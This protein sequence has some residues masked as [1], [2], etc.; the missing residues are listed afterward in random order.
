MNTFLRKHF[1]VATWEVVGVLVF[2]VFFSFL[3]RLT[4]WLNWSQKDRN[5]LDLLDLWVWWDSGGLQYFVMLLA[6]ALIWWVI[7]RLCR[8]WSL[9]Y[10]L[11]LH[12]LGLP[13]FILAARNGYYAVSDYFGMDHLEGNGTIWDVYIPSLFYG[14]QFGLFHAYNHFRE[15]QRKLILEGELRQAALRSELSAIKAQL[16]PHFLYNVFNTINASLPS[17]QENT[18][19]LIAKLSDLFR[20]QLRASRQETVPLADELT[21]VRNYLDLEKERFGDRLEIDVQVGDTLLTEPVP[22]M[23]LQPLVENS[24]K[25][26]LARQ[27]EGGRLE[28]SIHR[29]EGK[30]HFR[31]ADTGIGV[32]DKTTLFGSGVGITNTQMRLQKMYR[33]S[34]LFA[35]NYPRGLAVE[36]SL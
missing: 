16:N 1:G 15:N 29:R 4:L 25:H 9:S 5:P 36:F 32:S 35:D 10:R 8:R 12:L 3:Y 20:Y 27:V 6:T 33:S 21:F 23:I 34:L 30:L 13:L 14:V 18:R 19:K 22:P 17:E 26:G 11:L 28:I 2:Y 24:I 31:I 7:F